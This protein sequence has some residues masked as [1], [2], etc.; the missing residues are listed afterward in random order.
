MKVVGV[1]GSYRVDGV[2]ASLVKETLA[3]AEEQGAQTTLVYL[4][5][6]HIEFCTNCRMCTQAAEK[7]PLPFFFEY[8]MNGIL[9]QCPDADALVI[10][11]P[12]NFFAIKALTKRFIE[13][14]LP[15]S[16][17]PR[18][19][20]TSPRLRSYKRLKL[21]VQIYSAAMPV[22]FGRLFRGSMRSLQIISRILGAK[23]VTTIFTGMSA[24]NE[25]DKAS[26]K[27]LSKAR[28][29]GTKLTSKRL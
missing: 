8:D 12:V 22:I 9:Q 29:A 7:E 13:Q 23:P 28:K 11:A 4:K 5:D 17:W 15:F 18:G 10:A 26:T 21:S 2:I 6:C 1:I 24:I 25:T 3:A 16:Y 19:T 27:A 14:L 20:R